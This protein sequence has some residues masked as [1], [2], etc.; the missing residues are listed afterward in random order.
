MPVINTPDFPFVTHSYDSPGYESLGYDSPG[1]D[2]PGYENL[3]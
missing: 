3:A 1:Y 2:S